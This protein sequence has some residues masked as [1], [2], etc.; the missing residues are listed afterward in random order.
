MEIVV[1]KLHLPNP[2]FVMLNGKS[3]NHLL[4]AARVPDSPNPQRLNDAPR[5]ALHPNIAR[6][7]CLLISMTA[8]TTAMKRNDCY[9]QGHTRAFI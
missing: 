6:N 4:F 2:P 7:G 8:C 1:G 3:S 5:A 9:W